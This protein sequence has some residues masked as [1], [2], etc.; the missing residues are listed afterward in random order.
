MEKLR[1]Y[2]TSLDLIVQIYQLTR[3]K[4]LERDY[5]LVD[6]IRRAAIS[7]VTNIAE[8]NY[9]SRKQFINY[10]LIASGSANEVVSLLT[11]IQLV[12]GIDTNN[13]QENYKILGKQIN[14]FRKTL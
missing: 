3:E 14:A 7:I 13:L 12:Y 5:S 2:K 6:Q 11:I 1:I 8:G 10:L 4:L 9:R